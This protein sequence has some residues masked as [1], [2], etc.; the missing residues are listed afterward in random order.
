MVMML[1][2]YNHYIK[3]NEKV[4]KQYPKC[5]KA[6]PSNSSSNIFWWM[7][8]SFYP[9]INCGLYCRASTKCTIADLFTALRSAIV[10]NPF[11]NFILPDFYMMLLEVS[12]TV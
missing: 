12:S 10:G 4:N 8:I 7:K 5:G 2:C 6:N 9:S 1:G 11:E 3:N